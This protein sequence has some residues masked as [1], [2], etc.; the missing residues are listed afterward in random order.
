MKKVKAILVNAE[1]ILVSI[2][3]IIPIIWIV[4]ASFN[5]G[6]G[7]STSSL[8]PKHLTFENYV[9][10]FK[11]T[12]YMTWFINTL[13]VALL[14]TVVS[15]SLIMVTAWIMSRFNF[16]GKK[17]S[18]LLILILSMFPSF[19]S[20]TAIYTL[21]NMLN[22]IGKPLALVFVYSAGAIPFNVWL[23]KG[24]LDGIPKTIDEA[25]YIDG[26]GRFNTFFR[27]TIPM[28]GPIITYCA[29]SQFMMP[30][31]DYILPNLLLTGDKNKTLAVGI[32]SMI[33]DKEDK[34]FTM[35]AAGAVFVAIPITI[36]YLIFQKYLVEGISSGAS[37]E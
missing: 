23:V 9:N 12:N 17:T 2:I 8:I 32:Y 11:K 10:L 27:I 22:L 1:L 37:K 5:K 26:S 21:F 28:S 33:T 3:V 34:N 20:M 36:I 29:V 16:K 18:L 19:L 30:W 7:L 24:Y 6:D 31:M 35:F 13:E 14:N 15:V 25:A 4:L